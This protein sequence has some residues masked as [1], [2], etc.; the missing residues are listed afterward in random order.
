[1]SGR[2]PSPDVQEPVIPL[3]K[4]ESNSGGFGPKPPAAQ[5][6]PGLGQL[7]KRGSPGNGA[8]A[9][10][11]LLGE[12]PVAGWGY[13]QDGQGESMEGRG[14][15]GCRGRGSIRTQNVVCAWEGALPT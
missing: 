11:A 5:L 9:A 13:C 4:G 2:I 7:H 6:A 15:P 10:A 1:M 3:M 8:C 14:P 12:G